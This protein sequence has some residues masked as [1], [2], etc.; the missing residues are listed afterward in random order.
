MQT[1][2]IIIPI[3]NE[4][5]NIRELYARLLKT[6]GRHFSDFSYEIIFI[7]DGSADRSV[8]TVTTLR[9]TDPCVHLIQFSRNFGHHIAMAA[10]FDAA[11]GDY[12][13]MMDGDLQDQPEEIIRL[14]QKLQE[15]YDVVYGERVNKKFGY[16]KN[17]CSRAFNYLISRM[18]DEK[19]VISSTIFRIMTRQVVEN[20]RRLREQNRYIVGIVGWVGFRH[21]AQA[22]EHGQRFSGKSKYNLQKQFQLALNA[23][24]SFSR[25]PLRLIIKIGLVFVFISF[26]LVAYLLYRYVAYDVPVTGWTSLISSVFVVGGVQIIILG[27]LGEYLGRNYM[28]SKQR[29]LY[30]IRHSSLS[31]K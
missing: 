4:E 12:V 26:L 16:I 11:T 25:Y 3:Y 5:G 8:E 2:S 29:P 14:Y 13:V 1:L 24:F 6:L 30:V 10:G 18:I 9:G 17:L 27:I 21:A 7:D 23:I 15:G 28:E 22:V 19:I 31:E 20:I